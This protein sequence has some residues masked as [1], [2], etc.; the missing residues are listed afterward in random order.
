MGNVKKF[1]AERTRHKR[2]YDRR[3]NERQ[4]QSSESKVVSSKALDASLVITECSRTKSDEHI[5]SS[6]SRTYITHVMEAD[7]R[8]VN[9]Q[10]PSSEFLGKPPLQP[11][12]NHSVVRQPNAF[13]S[14][15]PR[16]SKPRF[17][18]QV[19][20]KNILSKPVT[21]HYLPNV[22][23][24]APVKPHHVNAPSSSRNSKKES[25][26]SNDMAHNYF[27]EEARKKTQDRN[28]NLKPREMPSAR[29]HHTPN[30]C[31]PRPRSNNQTFR[32]W[33]ASKSSNVKLKVVQK[34]D[35]SRNSSSFSD[36]KHFV[37]LTCQKCVFNANHDARVTKF[38][39]K[40]NLRAKKPSHKT[41]TSN[42]K[43]SLGQILAGHMFSTTK[44]FVVQKKINNPRSCLR[45]K[46]MGRV[47]KTV[48]LRWIPTGKIFTSSTTK[49]GSEPPNGSNEDIT[50]PHECE[51]T[52][53]VSAAVVQEPVVSTG[54]PSSMRIDQDTPSTSTS[55]TTQEAQS[56]VIPTSVKEDDHGIEVAH[57]DN[58]L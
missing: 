34:A 31:T 26:G 7:I 53:N 49:V 45:W 47:F 11:S 51:E 28:R 58:D 33:L 18:S 14:E 50:N 5:T 22:R 40:V 10:V 39:N 38:L 57:M 15:R 2:Q 37:C 6:S 29:T 13:N 36:S 42:T 48:G 3:M 54:I 4:M 56:H 55:E 44:S 46:P 43:K 24:S 1:V 25:Y 19:D 8:P 20:E 35:H 32:N 23:E 41:T 30:A 12:R 16:I 9:D 21:P 27:L 52:L 17:A